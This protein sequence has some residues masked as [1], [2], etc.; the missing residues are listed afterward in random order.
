MFKLGYAKHPLD[1]ATAAPPFDTVLA[2]DCAYHFKT[3]SAFLSQSFDRLAPGGRIALADICFTPGSLQKPFMRA[4][5][6]LFGLMPAENIIS[7]EDYVREMDNLGYKDVQLEDIS[8]D[9]FPGFIK[10]L[11][12]RGIGWWAFANFI[13]LWTEGGARFVIVS[14]VKG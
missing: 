12:G 1:P 6:R 13:G 9:V 2:L 10:F 11:K 8:K 4:F 7:T 5:V 14:A 3:R